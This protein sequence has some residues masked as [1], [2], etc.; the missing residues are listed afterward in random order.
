[1]AEQIITKKCPKCNQT[2]PFCEF[3][4]NR[5]RKGGLD[6]Y[7]RKCQAKKRKTQI[8]KNYRRQYEQCKKCKDY[9]KQYQQKN[10][11][12][13]NLSQRKRRLSNHT[14]NKAVGM[15]GYA[16]KMGRIKPANSFKCTYCSMQAREYHHHK[17]YEPEN[18]FVIIP[19]CRICH[20]KIHRVK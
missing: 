14:Q 15:V 1:M 2:K 17:G 4:K 10:R 9:R 20:C 6:V 3:N 5:A 18:W 16:V 13:F 19:V 7:C 12:I 8:Y 11:Q